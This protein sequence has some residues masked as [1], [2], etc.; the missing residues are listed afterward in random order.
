M[1]IV[2][3]C[4]K[5]IPQTTKVSLMRLKS[6]TPVLCNQCLKTQ[7]LLSAINSLASNQMGNM[8]KYSTN[9]V[10]S[11]Q[12]NG[13][14]L[15][16]AL[17][18]YMTSISKII[19]SGTPVTGTCS[20]YTS[21]DGASDYSPISIFQVFTGTSKIVF[22]GQLYVTS[23][24][25]KDNISRLVYSSDGITWID[26]G[27]PIQDTIEDISSDGYTWLS[28]GKNTGAMG[29]SDGKYWSPI[30]DLMNIYLDSYFSNC[31][32]AGTRWLISGCHKEQ[33]CIYKSSDKITWNLLAHI[34]SQTTCMKYNGKIL[35]IAYKTTP[36]IQYS[37]NNG[38]N[39]V[40]SLSAPLV[41]PSGC[42][43]IAWN[44]SLWV[45][46]GPGINTIATST[47]GIIWTGLG[48]HI[49]TEATSICW[50]KAYWVAGGSGTNSLAYSMNG[51]DWIGLGTATFTKVTSVCSAFINN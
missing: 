34:P 41:F 28:I 12:W 1:P 14:S 5:L 40:N 32:W 11:T 10:F 30:N 50:N 26:S 33:N 44:G 39:L 16:P 4:G 51:S 35:L 45:A 2:C 29:S 7:E 46:V 49:F 18:S 25:N 37:L 8:S 3:I 24:R 21:S 6:A 22:N 27:K 48:N 31:T 42:N 15:L 36:F 23:V 13:N 19:A 9:G 17:P 47:D 20:V 38:E 43:D